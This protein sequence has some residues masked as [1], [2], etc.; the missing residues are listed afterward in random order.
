VTLHLVRHAAPPDGVVAPGD[1]VLHDRDG[2]W[3]LAES[4]VDDDR[5]VE[6]VVG[7]E[8]VVVW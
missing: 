1:V 8:R 6:L 3:H 2:V 4:P 7:S 5:V